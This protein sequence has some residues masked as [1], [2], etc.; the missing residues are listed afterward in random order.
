MDLVE[1]VIKLHFDYLDLKSKI[2]AGSKV[3]LKLNLL[4]KKSPDTAVITHPCVVVGIIRN[5]KAMGVEDIVVGDSPG[6]PFTV[7]MLKSIYSTAGLVDMAEKEN[8]KLNYNVN[9]STVP[10]EKNSLNIR[11]FDII[12]AALQCDF[13]IN[14]CKLKTHGMMTLSGAVK[15]MFGVIPGLTKPEYHMRYP[16]TNDFAEMLVELNRTVNP[17]VTFV[18]AIDAM[19]GDGP[20]GGNV[21]HVGLLLSGYNQYNVDIALC[22]IVGIEPDSVP[23]ANIAINKELCPRSIEDIDVIGD[24]KGDTQRFKLPNSVKSVSFI[25][26]VPSFLKG[27]FRV[28]S[29]VLLKPKPLVKKDKCIGCGKCAESCPAKTIEIIDRKAIINYKNCIKCYC[30]HEMCPVTAIDF[31]RSFLTRTRGE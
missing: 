25:D 1:S 4:M 26:F 18:D 27:P 14:V 20:S 29:D 19:E 2:S 22:D 7:N 9:S 6:G 8:V 15:N 30:C 23:T 17:Y 28:V 16:D 21:K 24:Y 11:N 12:D 10:A 13:I 5:L 3:F 31:K